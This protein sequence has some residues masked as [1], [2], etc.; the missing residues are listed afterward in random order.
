MSGD[1]TRGATLAAFDG[2][3]HR[4]TRERDLMALLWIIR[5]MLDRSGTIE[6]LLPRRLRSWGSGGTGDVAAAL[7]SFSARA[8]ALD[9]AAGVWTRAARRPRRLA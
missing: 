6:G 4:W 8:M 7:D 1:S 9:L 2:L 3:V 5:Q